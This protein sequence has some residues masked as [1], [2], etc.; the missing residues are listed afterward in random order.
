MK[1]IRYQTHRRK[2]GYGWLLGDKVGPIQGDIFG[3]YQRG[4]ARTSIDK[5]ELLPPVVPSKLICVARNFPAHAEEHGVSVPDVPA[6]FLKP[7]SAVIG[8]GEA[9]Q[10]PPQAERVEHE[11]ELAVVIGRF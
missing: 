10:I 6:M 11:G 1:I 3:A 9:I 8:H 4:E 5:V 7:P 2:P